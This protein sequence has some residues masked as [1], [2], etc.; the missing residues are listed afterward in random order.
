MD[1]AVE[2]NVPIVL[3]IDEWVGKCRVWFW[4]SRSSNNDHMAWCW[5][6]SM[7]YLPHINDGTVTNL[8][9]EWI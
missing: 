4:K 6:C 3:V 1:C 7:D 2:D 5:G 9:N 8:H